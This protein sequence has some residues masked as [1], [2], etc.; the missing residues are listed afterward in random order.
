MFRQ[1]L[2]SE[3]IQR[4]SLF[5]H[6]KALEK[7]VSE[8]IQSTI[9]HRRNKS[10]EP[11]SCQWNRSHYGG[12]TTYRLFVF[13]L[14][15]FFVLE[16]LLHIV[17][18]FTQ[19]SV[20]CNVFFSTVP[21]HD[22]ASLQVLRHLRLPHIRLYIH[23]AGPCLAQVSPCPVHSDVYTAVSSH[24]TWMR[25]E[26]PFDTS[27]L[28]SKTTQMEETGGAKARILKHWSRCTGTWS[29]SD[30]RAGECVVSL[31][32]GGIFAVMQIYSPWEPKALFSTW[33]VID[34]LIPLSLTRFI[35]AVCHSIALHIGTWHHLFYCRGLY[36]SHTVLFFRKV[37]NGQ[38]HYESLYAAVQCTAM[39][40]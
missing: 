36:L 35:F 30:Y 5:F 27:C 6:N 4:I 20:L 3:D 9:L 22:T 21:I 28:I 19:F 38:R 8:C 1:W 26:K 7:E 25:W 11:Y 16:T 31:W 24:S 34:F 23:S 40:V 13:T 37:G 15:L 17:T 10:I 14:Q 39:L 12:G 33:E 18:D 29:V 2:K 32:W